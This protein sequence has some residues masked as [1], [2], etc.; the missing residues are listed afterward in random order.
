MTKEELADQR[1]YVFMMIRGSNDLG[2][3]LAPQRMQSGHLYLGSEVFKSYG[4]AV[5]VSTEKMEDEILVVN[6][7]KHHAATK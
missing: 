3:M 6:E 1:K 7:V 2:K 5:F 4:T